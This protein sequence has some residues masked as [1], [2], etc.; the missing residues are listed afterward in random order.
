[1]AEKLVHLPLKNDG[2]KVKSISRNVATW[3]PLFG[4]FLKKRGIPPSQMLAS[5]AKVVGFTGSPTNNLDL[6]VMDDW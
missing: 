3:G 1:M 2:S 5:S 6:V 4:D